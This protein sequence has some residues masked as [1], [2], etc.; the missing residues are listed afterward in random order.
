VE[1][2][3]IDALKAQLKNVVHVHYNYMMEDILT[4]VGLLKAMIASKY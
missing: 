2:L 1:C 3:I 4:I